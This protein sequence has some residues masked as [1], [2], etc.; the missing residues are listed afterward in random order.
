M[1]TQPPH[2]VIAGGGVAAIEAVAALRSLAGLRPRITVLTPTRELPPRPDSVAAPFG[3]GMPSALPYDVIQR[4][5]PFDVHVGTLA[6]VQPQARRVIDDAGGV[7][8]Y[9]ALLLAIGAK[10]LPAVPGAITFGG[11]ADVAAVERVLDETAR[12]AFVV[13]PGSAWALPVYELAIMAATELRNRGREPQ[14]TVVTPE[15]AP[16]AAFGAEA[17]A[18]IS[19]LLA[20]RGIALRTHARVVAAAD[21]IL[22]VEGE[23]HVLADR[24][25]ALPRLTGPGV[26][27]LP[28]DHDGFLPVDEHARVRGVERVYAAGDATTFALKQGGLATQQADA[29]AETIAADLGGA[30]RPTPFRPVL[31]GLLLT[32]GEPLYLRARLTPDGEPLDAADVSRRPLWSPP[33]KVAGRYLAPLLATARPPGLV[34]GALQDLVKT[35]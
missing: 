33:G 24:V 34:T 14:I 10:P 13:P 1:T 27:G 18:A 26:V 8:E 35:G 28:Q 19:A 23:P 31:R 30:V 3:F 6:Q 9:D 12:I 15:S 21:G 17:G 20:E 7:L 29:A 2:I 25:V 5:A 32:G 16:L 22:A 4:K 11:P